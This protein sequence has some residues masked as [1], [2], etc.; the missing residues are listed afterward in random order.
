MIKITRTNKPDVLVQNA[1]N[2]TKEYLIAKDLYEASR[3]IENKKALEK[4]EKKYNHL[5]VK[6]S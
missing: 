2:W 5:E 6:T 4:T 1:E 3:S